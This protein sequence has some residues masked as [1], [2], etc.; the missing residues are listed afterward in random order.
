MTP[1]GQGLALVLLEEH[2]QAVHEIPQGLQFGQVAQHLLQVGP[3]PGLIR[4]RRFTIKKRR[5][6]MKADFSLLVRP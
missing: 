5:L 6:Q 1:P 4:S 3:S 2:L